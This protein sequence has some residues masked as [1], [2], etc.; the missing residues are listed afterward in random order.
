VRV[1]DVSRAVRVLGI[2]LGRHEHRAVAERARVEDG[3][4]LADDALVDQVLDPA[5]HLVLRGLRQRRDARKRAALQRELAL[6]QVHDPL[7]QLVERDRG[8]V[9][10]RAQL[11]LRPGY[12]SHRATSFAW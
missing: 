6:H 3:R 11:G 1:D 9:L 8:A 5:Q 12:A 10:A 7:V 2:D 4:D